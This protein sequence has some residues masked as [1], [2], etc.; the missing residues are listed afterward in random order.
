[1]MPRALGRLH[2][3]TD[4]QLQR[5]WSHADL[6]AMLGEAG[7]DVVQLRDKRVLADA[8]RLEVAQEVRSR[9]APSVAL[10]INDHVAV[11]RDCGAQGV[12]LGAHDVPVRQA[13]R[14]LGVAACIGGTANTLAQARQRFEEPL[15]YIGVGPVFA[16]TSKHNPAHSLGLDGLARIVAA[17]PVPVIAIGGI[18]PEDVEGVLRSGAHG[19]A[20]LSGAVCQPDPR[21][22]VRRYRHVLDVALGR[23]A[24]PQQISGEVE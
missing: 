1:M 16:T 19:I 8:E 7:A 24:A 20:V 11:A 21:A 15:D 13:R 3:L 18:R 5:R 17:S 4:V 6:A 10:L 14:I 22:A 2:V 23:W 12:H 9:L